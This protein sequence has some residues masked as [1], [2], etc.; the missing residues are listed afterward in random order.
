MRHRAESAGNLKSSDK[1]AV[2]SDGD[3][4]KIEP[5][6][7]EIV[8]V[9]Q[10]DPW[11]I[12][13]DPL[14]AWPGWYPYPGLFIGGP[15][16]AFG[17]GFG[18]GLFAG[19]GWGWHS[20]GFDWHGGGAIFQRNVYISHSTSFV[21]RGGFGRGA[22]SFGHGVPAAHGFGH[23]FGEPHG[24]TGLHSGA[25]SGFDR[26]GIAHTNAFRGASS[27]GRFPWRFRPPIDSPLTHP[28]SL[29]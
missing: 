16:L 17:V 12:Y 19:F 7:P 5:A 13:G 29:R 4:I 2:T 3:T 6:N 25:F 24:F 28:N 9:P 21:N 26:G 22:G 14:I 1:E 23:S 10:F 18:I 27:F 11:L 8:Y 20:W 15:G